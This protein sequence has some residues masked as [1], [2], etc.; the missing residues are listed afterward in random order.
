[1][2]KH[3]SFKSYVFLK[4]VRKLKNRSRL[5]TQ[6]IF[7]YFFILLL[8]SQTTIYFITF[9][10]DSCVKK[11]GKAAKE[12]FNFS[13]VF[14]QFLLLFAYV[15]VCVFMPQQNKQQLKIKIYRDAKKKNKFPFTMHDK[16]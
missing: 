13:S 10:K 2:R 16:A 4:I 6:S 1:M 15:C 8:P 7:C 3:F 12:L 14:F 9:A 11:C 5:S